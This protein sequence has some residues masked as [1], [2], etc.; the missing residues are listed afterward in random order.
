M[1]LLLHRYPKPIA[2]YTNAAI[3]EIYLALGVTGCPVRYLSLPAWF[4]R[5][6]PKWTHVLLWPIFVF[7]EVLRISKDHQIKAIYFD[8]S[9]PG[10]SWVIKLFWRHTPV[11]QRVGDFFFGYVSWSKII[12]SYLE[13][14][15]RFLY[16]NCD[17]L[18][19]ISEPMKQYMVSS[20]KLGSKVSMVPEVLPSDF[21][22]D[23]IVNVKRSQASSDIRVIHHGSITRNRGVDILVEAHAFYPKV[24]IDIAG[25]GRKK[26]IQ[27]IK[28]SGLRYIGWIPREQLPDRVA[29]YS[30]GIVI[31]SKNIGNQFVLTTAALQYLAILDRVVLPRTFVSEQL[32]LDKLPNTFFYELG[33]ARSLADA[34][35]NAHLTTS[36]C[37][38][39][40]RHAFLQQYYS[41]HNARL[42]SQEVISCMKR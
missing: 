37:D 10:A 28:N 41:R 2:G 1:I 21:E 23:S 15:T 31:R 18:I 7:F 6:I 38:F 5:R 11:V 12:S 3:N 24:S 36:E 22:L 20:W 8:D 4:C 17:K 13:N 42:I 39:G 25:S 9:L 27:K 32:E 14:T 26:E 33:S 19:A 35:R 30:I 29:D 16:Q 40:V 34:I